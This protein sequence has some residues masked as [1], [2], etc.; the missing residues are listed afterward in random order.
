[1]NKARKNESIR[2]TIDL[3]NI[4]QLDP[5]LPL[6]VSAIRNGR[7][8]ESETI[9]VNEV[10]DV[11]KIPVKLEFDI[12]DRT[13]PLGVTLAVGPDVPD[14]EFAATD[15]YNHWISHK[16]AGWSNLNYKLDKLIVPEYIYPWW[17]RCKTYT[18]RGKVVCPDGRPV[19]GAN[20]QA[21]DVDRFW[22]W[23]GKSDVASAVTEADGT[24]EMSFRWC[25]SWWLWWRPLPLYPI[26]PK[27]KFPPPPVIK[28]WEID[29]ILSDGI[30][31]VLDKV[32]QIGPMPRPEQTPSLEYFEELRQQLNLT[33]SKKI[34]SD[35]KLEMKD[36][37][38]SLSTFI[39]NRLPAA[40]ELRA[41][42][43]WPFHP[44][45][46]RDCT[47]D[48]IFKVTQDCEQPDTVIYEEDCGDTRWNIPTLLDGVTL[49]ANQEA[50]C[51]GDPEVPEGDCF[52][53]GEVGC[54]PV[55][56]IGGNDPLSP[57][58]AALLG[59]AHPNSLDRPFGGTLS[60]K[61]VFG[62]LAEH[63][64]YAIEYSP[65][66]INFNEMTNA[67]MSNFYRKYWGEPAG[68]GAAQ[69]NTIWFKKEEIDGH[70][71]LKSRHKYE[72]ENPFA[73]A[74]VWT[75]NADM[76]VRWVSDTL[77]DGLYY[78]RVVG[79][80][81]TGAG[82]LINGKVLPMCLTEGDAT[83]AVRIDN[84]K[85]GIGYH[86][87]SV[88]SHP[89]GSGTVHLCTEEPDCDF[90]SIIVNE[91]GANERIIQACDIVKLAPTDTV[92]I[93][94]NASVPPNSEDG[95]LLGYQ[96]T[97]HWGESGI[98]NVLGKGTLAAD[99][100]PQFGP[101]YSQAVTQGAVRPL[102]Y[103]GD[104]KVTLTGADF[105]DCCAYLLK[106]RVW[107]RTTSGCDHPYY[108]HYNRCE[109]SFTLIKTDLLGTLECPDICPPTLI[110]I[111]APPVSVRNERTGGSGPTLDI[112]ESFT[113]NPGQL[114]R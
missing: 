7:V 34:E 5:E 69:W 91:G 55:E 57:V 10:K 109:Y 71:V 16:D 27:L 20:V 82:Q 92:T 84:R 108:F 86:A 45:P 77:P 41:L 54:T 11:S 106:L 58:A 73:A 68:G 43:V 93:H 78:L 96:L 26:P 62:D 97:A 33:R 9:N 21:I 6:K 75:S 47:P 15:T 3:S 46:W 112:S 2:T 19:P 23:C 22:I 13:K 53:F 4:K 40:P 87:P 25:C 51:A 36:D 63:D 39:T 64:Y 56:Y 103:G 37:M 70:W 67:M 31:R 30:Q 32:P 113:N 49:V 74:G 107:K 95:H 85:V 102:W 105:P 88:S 98:F 81:I 100:D 12:G 28:Y 44:W 65:D 104:F 79:Y 38:S 80:E 72:D 50:C 59:Y 66:N 8:L 89:C 14:E 35:T 76:L 94:F 99:P 101:S 90:R 83:L 17:W 42:N 110:P 61:G 111:P 1:M 29:P 18:V 52:V 60:I 24:F 114:K 48:I